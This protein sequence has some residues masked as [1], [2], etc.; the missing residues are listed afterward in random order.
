M[1]RLSVK[2]QDQVIDQTQGPDDELA[3]WLEGNLAVGKYP[4]GYE[5]EYQDISAEV[6]QQQIN[7]D[8]LNYLASTDW[9]IIREVDEGTPCPLEVKTERAAARAR[10]IKE[11]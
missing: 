4:E 6:I 9:L 11:Q 2:F 10:I 7:Q 5:V 1:K 3:L 8:A